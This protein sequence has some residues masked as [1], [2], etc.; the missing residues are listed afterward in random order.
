MKKIYSLA[1]TCFITLLSVAQPNNEKDALK[2]L[3]G[4]FEVQFKYAE[5]FAADT[6]YKLHPKYN[7]NGL[8]WVVA[9]EATDQKFVLQHLLLADDSVIVK[10][11]REDWQFE[12]TNWW[13]Y[14]HDA[15]WKL[16]NGNKQQVRGQ[17]TQ[18]VWGVDDEPRY[19]G[20][21]AWINNN[22]K[23]YWENTTDS[24]LPRREYSKRNDYNVMQ[25][26]NRIIITPNGWTHEQDNKKIIRK[27][28]SSDVFLAE[29]K[30]YN[31][32]TKT[33]DDKCK[34]AAVYWQKHKQF[35][36]VVRQSWEELLNGK[37]NVTLVSKADGKYMYQQLDEVEKQS[38]TVVQQKEKIKSVLVKF[39]NKTTN[40]GVATNTS[41]TH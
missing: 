2:K 29:E 31:I 28:G 6:A 36:A 15:N 25:R 16:V 7:A 10:H 19:Q 38:L 33:S 3:C 41:V 30:G 32:Y 20:S 12:Q 4:C 40:A 22:G 37:N 27:D 34:Q 11:W 21:S 26:T 13:M 18:T 5:T 14:N 17:W 24:P 9:E 8:E 35:W 39:M 1:T 23:Y